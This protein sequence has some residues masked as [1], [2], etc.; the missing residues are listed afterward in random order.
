MEDDILI[1]EN[2]YRNELLNI[3]ESCLSILVTVSEIEEK[4]YDEEVEDIIKVKSKTYKVILFAQDKLIKQI[5]N[6]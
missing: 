2:D 4:N 6:I 3:I 1:H 5:K